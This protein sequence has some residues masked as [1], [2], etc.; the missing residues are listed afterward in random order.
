LSLEKMGVVQTN[1]SLSKVVFK[2]E[3]RFIYSKV[4]YSPEILRKCRQVL[5]SKPS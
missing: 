4:F 1:D 3:D 5:N 2:R